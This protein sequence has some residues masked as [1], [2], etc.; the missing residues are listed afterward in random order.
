MR[1]HRGPE[2]LRRMRRKNSVQYPHPLERSDDVSLYGLRLYVR[3]Y[4]RLTQ[5]TEKSEV[6]VQREPPC[7]KKPYSCG[8][9]PR[10]TGHCGLQTLITFVEA[11]FGYD[12]L[13]VGYGTARHA[14]LSHERW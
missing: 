1:T 11:G 5:C 13:V 10:N 8:F 9:T 14:W 6:E 2:A 7:R 3:R 12:Y 4:L